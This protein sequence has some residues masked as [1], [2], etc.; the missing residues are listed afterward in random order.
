MDNSDAVIAWVMFVLFAVAMAY[1]LSWN[2]INSIVI[3]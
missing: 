1:I 2:S 3:P